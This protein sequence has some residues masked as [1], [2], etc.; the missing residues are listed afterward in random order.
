MQAV[1]KAVF[2]V[3]NDNYYD[4]YLDKYN[5]LI[6]IYKTNSNNHP[7]G[8]SQKKS[9]TKLFSQRFSSCL[10]S[11]LTVIFKTMNHRG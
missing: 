6:L 3:I 2:K 4:N 8:Q 11:Y 9:I 7:F 10:F 5:F 1:Q